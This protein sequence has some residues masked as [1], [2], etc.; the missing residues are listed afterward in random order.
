M[1]MYLIGNSHIDPVWL[2]QWHEGVS[3][4][5]ATFKS[6]LDRMRDYTDFKFTSACASY[7]EWIE[8]LDPD[9]FKEI[10]QRINEGRWE[11]VGGWYLQ[12]DCNMPDGESF[13]RQ[14]LVG[15]RYFKEKFGVTAKTGYNVDSFGHNANLP[16]IL[17]L[18]GMDN[19]IFMRPSRDEQG[20]DEILFS[21]ESDDGSRV[22]AYR[23]PANYNIDL[24][25]YRDKLTKV[26]E[27]SDEQKIEMM[28]FYGVGNHGGGPTIQL[29]DAITKFDIG[30]KVYATPS[31]YFEVMKNKKLPVIK[32]ELQHH[33]RG[34]YSAESH[35][36]AANR[37]CE[38]YLLAAEKMC[39]MAKELTGW[40]YPAKKLKKAW[41]NLLFNQFHDI[42][43]G[44]IIKSARKDADYLFGEVMSIAEQAIV[45]AMQ[46]IAWNIDTLKGEKLPSYKEK[47][48]FWQHE[49]LGTPLVVF[50]PHPWTVKRQLVINSIVGRMTDSDG[51]EIPL[52]KIR[53]E[54]INSAADK[55][56]TVFMADVPPMGYAVYRMF[57]KANQTENIEV[58]FKTEEKVFENSKIK[59]EFDALTGDVK[60]FYDKERKKALIDKPCSAVVLDETK[61]DTWAHNEKE[62]GATVGMFSMPE[63]KILEDG[64]I[65]KIIRVTTS[66]GESVLVRDYI[67]HKDSCELIV[68]VK[69][70]LREECRTLK[71]T[72]P[73]TDEK[74][75]A[76][77]PYGTITRCG[78]TGEEFCGSWIASS[79]ICIA[80]DSK[81]GYDTKDGMMRMTVLRSA[82]YADHFGQSER[83][84]FCEYMD[85]GKH[86]FTYS[87]F[88]YTDNASAEKKAE[89]LNFELRYVLGTFHDG[90]L[91]E[92]F[93][94]V[95]CDRD[96][97][98]IS[99]VKQHED[100]KNNVVR[101][102][103]MNGDNA[104]VSVKLFDKVISTDISHNEMKTFADNGDELDLIEWKK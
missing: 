11:I 30:E 104:T 27:L 68:R 52:Q 85:L 92:K 103:E 61:C 13:A 34:C 51:N 82:A 83:D 17:K 101:M 93:G 79:G 91:P 78:Y 35:I 46:K 53:G 38:R 54:Q 49:K 44:C 25:N 73:M 102:Y 32:D 69:T 67:L 10:K 8:K 75:I 100:S 31:E 98:I 77:I 37:K 70:E 74:V 84:D 45:F 99:A 87:I 60:Y 43:C 24:G 63:F 95:E 80:N 7:Y 23:N 96:N 15:Q 40:N 14:S 58:E 64:N 76:K 97:V 62:L 33:A 65:R 1:K 3:E 22:T 5:L 6:A 12:P 88:P 90:I 41:K 9:M 71:F 81:Y 36:K 16:K 42:L 47:M 56:A 66:C 19:Y 20:R 50:N 4:V 89:E 48:R 26:R 39:V 18:S 55:F 2:W 21:W 72:F 28:A 59:V 57:E 86:E 29:I 94:S